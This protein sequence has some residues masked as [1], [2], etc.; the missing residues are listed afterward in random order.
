MAISTSR[1]RSGRRTEHKGSQ[2]GRRAVPTVAA[3]DV[4]MRTPRHVDL[5]T[6]AARWQ[7]ALDAAEGALDAARG[8]LSPSELISRRGTLARER[9][10]TAELLASVARIAGTD[11]LP[12]LSPVPLTTRMLGLPQNARGCLFD[13][14]GVLTDAARLQ[15]WAWS[16]VLDDFLERLNDETGW[17]F[18]PFDPDADYRAYLDGRPRLEGLHAFLRSRGIRL[19][20]GEPSDP[21]DAHTAHG[22]ARRKGE[23]LA[24]QLQPRGVTA[25][26]GARRYL[27]AA[28]HAGLKR[29]VISASTSTLAMLELAGLSTLVEERIDVDVMRDEG[30]RA[31]PAPDLLLV[32]CRR[33]GI[34]PESAVT[35]THTTAGVAAGRAADVVVYGVADGTDGAALLDAG[36]DRVVPS[37]DALLDPRLVELT[38]DR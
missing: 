31:R 12:W 36:A 2:G 28:G 38:P 4:T 27:E 30:L 22:L 11:P 34:E 23:L 37:V 17:R 13:L 16:Q 26:T 24:Q 5:S 1:P 8:S 29:A 10:H 20:E 25:L 15:A 7:L 33:L 9:K 35:L 32:A 18:A 6:T 21:S 3:P 14:E 19:P